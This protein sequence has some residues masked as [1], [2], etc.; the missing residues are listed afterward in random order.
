MNENI[1]YEQRQRQLACVNEFLII[2]S[3]R[4]HIHHA[5][6]LLF[7][8]C[9]D[10]RQF[11][12]HIFTKRYYILAIALWKLVCVNCKETEKKRRKIRVDVFVCTSTSRCVY[13]NVSYVF[14]YSAIKLQRLHLWADKCTPIIIIHTNENIKL[15][16]FVFIYFF[17]C[18]N[19]EHTYI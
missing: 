19:R 7:F 17:F 1:S 16:L 13:E 6:F 11:L 4:V 15:D 2:F 18:L 5:I 9:C 3:I 8:C 14:F 12:R 10:F